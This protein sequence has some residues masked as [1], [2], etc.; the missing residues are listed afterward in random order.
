MVKHVFV[1]IMYVTKIKKNTPDLTSRSLP[2]S[3]LCSLSC[4]FLL[5]LP[6]SPKSFK[7]ASIHVWICKWYRVLFY[8]VK[9][10]IKCLCVLCNLLPFTYYYIFESSMFCLSCTHYP[11]RLYIY[12]TYIPAILLLDRCHKGKKKKN[13]LT[14]TVHIYKILI[15]RVNI[16]AK[17]RNKDTRSQMST[18]LRK[19]GFG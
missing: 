4:F 3:L 17:K 13:L 7:I 2:V 6:R 15:V 8:F 11:V 9:L 16:T 5:L 10:G 12:I 1:H 18:K 19:F 14:F